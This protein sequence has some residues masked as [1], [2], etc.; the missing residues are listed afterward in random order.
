MF[1]RKLKKAN[2][3]ISL[4]IVENKRYGKKVRQRIIK[5][6]GQAKDPK[7]VAIL[8]RAA[9]QML[10][11]LKNENT[12]TNPSHNYKE[13]P[14]WVKLKNIKSHKRM[15]RGI[16]DIFGKMYNDLNFNT[17]ITQGYKNSNWNNALKAMVLC[18]I[19]GPVSKRKTQWVL[20]EDYLV[21]YPL[22]KLYR[23]MDKVLPTKDKAMEIVLEKTKELH[24]G[25]IS[26]MLFDVTTLYFESTNDDEL[27]N[28]GF[29][30]DNKFKE[31]QVVLSLTTTESG[32]PIGHELFPGNTSEGNTLIDHIKSIKK[33]F[34]LEKVRLVADRAMFSEKNLTHLEEEGVEYIVAAKLRTMSN[35]KK[36]EF[37]SDKENILSS[38]V[39]GEK[40]VKDV[41][42]L[43]DISNEECDENELFGYAK[44]YMHN[45]RRLIVSY[46]GK[47]AAKDK[48]MRSRLV[49]RMLKKVEDGKIK[50]SN[51]ITNNGSK[52]FIKV[53]NKATVEMDEDKIKN[54]ARWDGLHGVITNNEKIPSQAI[55]EAYR[56]LWKIEDAFRLNKHDLKMRPIYHWRHHRIQSHILICYLAFALGRFTLHHLEAAGQKMSLAVCV[57]ALSRTEST[58]MESC[59][60][61][62]GNLYVIPG[63][64]KEDVQRIYKAFGIDHRV[65][66]YL[67]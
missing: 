15:N 13:I 63:P 62:D 28:F 6:V 45:G 40:N 44:D 37:L 2:G 25:T 59:D 47:R 9:K 5:T 30:K 16:F 4:R 27:R 10:I 3:A 14:D 46:S 49:E 32:L 66:A 19:A 64:V 29:S 54:D 51:L 61:S 55:L 35:N 26:V 36:E 12:S 33:K 48:K 50:I 21:N 8:E 56:N 24:D 18:R 20:S 17:L 42:D 52:K 60:N 1:V 23:T 53:V 57:D 43:S 11:L 58:I 22:E 39:K 38:F 7:D 67:I 31:V 34:D 65:E 41:V